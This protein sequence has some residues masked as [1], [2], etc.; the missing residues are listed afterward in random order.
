M[1]QGRGAGTCFGFYSS[2]GSAPPPRRP[3]AS[4]GPLP[5]P[6]PPLSVSCKARF[7]GRFSGAPS[8]C[9]L[10]PSARVEEGCSAINTDPMPFLFQVQC[11][12]THQFRF[13]TPQLGCCPAQ[14]FRD[15][16]RLQGARCKVQEAY[17]GMQRATSTLFLSVPMATR[18]RFVKV[19]GDLAPQDHKMRG[20]LCERSQMQVHNWPHCCRLPVT[21]CITPFT[22]PASIHC[23]AGQAQPR[24][25]NLT[26]T[27]VSTPKTPEF[28]VLIGSVLKNC[29]LSYALGPHP[30]SYSNRPCMVT[31]GAREPSLFVLQIYSEGW[32]LS[33]SCAFAGCTRWYCWCF[34]VYFRFL[35]S[36]A[37]HCVLYH[38]E[39]FHFSQFQPLMLI[40]L[41]HTHLVL[42]SISNVLGAV[43]CLPRILAPQSVVLTTG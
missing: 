1:L 13:S 23:P 11:P 4:A 40:I 21:V 43:E 25:Q 10:A 2:T 28:Q 8:N 39:H 37:L 34:A 19:A 41:T 36:Q 42:L 17:H 15:N 38:A 6:L 9:S 24:G 18:H 31:G 3:P 14:N 5:S 16:Y 30:P 33:F 27:P 32:V 20:W 12:C 35:A 26:I 22:A 7:S 29:A